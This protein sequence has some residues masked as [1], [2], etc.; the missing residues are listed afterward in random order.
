M[1]VWA[2][3]AVVLTRRREELIRGMKARSR[4][5]RAVQA[6]LRLALS[7]ALLAFEMFALSKGGM[8]QGSFTLWGWALTTIVVPLFAYLQTT[9]LVPLILNAVTQPSSDSSDRK[10]ADHP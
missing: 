6:V 4:G 9:A 10:D 8:V 1:V 5:Q 2:V 7:I 3:L